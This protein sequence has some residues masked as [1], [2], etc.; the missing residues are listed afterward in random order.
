M[1]I[2][3]VVFNYVLL[4]PLGELTRCYQAI[5][6][7]IVEFYSILSEKRFLCQEHI[8]TQSVIYPEIKPHPTELIINHNIFLWYRCNNSKT[9]GIIAFLIIEVERHFCICDR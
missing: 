5:Q 9:F 3:D 6:T 7:E 2:C 1:V 4:F 8:Y